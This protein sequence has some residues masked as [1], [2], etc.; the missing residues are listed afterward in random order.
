MNIPTKDLLGSRARFEKVFSEFWKEANREL[1]SAHYA[2]VKR[3]KTTVFALARAD[4]RWTPSREILGLSKKG[5][6]MRRWGERGRRV[7]D[8]P[9]PLLV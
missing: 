7:A 5:C 1:I 2:A 3:D 4:T 6:R 8:K 9:P